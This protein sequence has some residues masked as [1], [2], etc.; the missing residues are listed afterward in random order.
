VGEGLIIIPSPLGRRC[1]EGAD[2]GDFEAVQKPN[3]TTLSKRGE[4]AGKH[5]KKL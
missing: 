3:R 4:N 1:P 2:E 5:R